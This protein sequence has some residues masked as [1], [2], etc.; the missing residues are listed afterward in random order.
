M[1]GGYARRMNERS[2]LRRCAWHCIVRPLAP[3]AVLPAQVTSARL[4][5]G[6]LAALLLAMSPAWF[7]LAALLLLGATV[8]ERAADELALVRGSAAWADER[9][10]YVADNICN[11]LTFAGLGAG[12]RAGDT[13]WPRSAWAASRACPSPQCL[14]SYDVS[15]ASTVAAPM[16]LAGSTDL[17]LT[18]SC[19]SSRS[20]CSLAGLK[21]CWS[22][23]PS[24]RQLLRARFL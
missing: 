21:R 22:L 19:C 7:T 2:W 20:A 1:R 5:V 12:L 14:G 8:L 17:T 15:K 16:S 6:V 10:P 4:T 18:T 11:V 24:A 23:Q 13:V 9:Y 3:T